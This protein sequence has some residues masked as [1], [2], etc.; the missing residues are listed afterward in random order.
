[1]IRT[2]RERW[3]KRSVGL[4]MLELRTSVGS[5]AESGRNLAALREQ[6]RRLERGAGAGRTLPFGVVAL[7]AALPGGGLALGALHEVMGAGPDE[8]DGAAAA[9]FAAG[10]LARLARA[11]GAPVLWCLAA[12]DLYAPALAAYGLAPERLLLARCRSDEDILWT[13]EE[14]LRS[15]VL[16]A[17]IGEVGVLTP[18]AGRRL[19]LACEA[20]GTGGFVLRRWRSGT[21]AARQRGVPSVAAT[22]WRIA[23]APSRGAGEPHLTP[24]GIG[25]PL[26]RVE[27]LRCRG[28]LPRLW[29]MEEGDA[30][31]HVALAAELADRP[32]VPGRQPGLVAVRR[33]G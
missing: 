20:A 26:W 24:S 13:M 3:G 27:L 31:G 19:Q 18:T 12:D 7:D 33:A 22:R 6:V 29:L 5:G 17:V 1:M 11:E 28:G 14:G 2:Y 9:A 8:E 4:D 23:A 16:A 10:I 21:A 25:A 30:T 32:V 15:A